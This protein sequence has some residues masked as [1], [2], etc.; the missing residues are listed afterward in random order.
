MN[1]A[2]WAALT[3]SGD[4]L[5]LGVGLRLRTICIPR[6]YT[7]DIFS[8][9]R[10]SPHSPWSFLAGRAALVRCFDLG[11]RGRPLPA[12]LVGSK[13]IHVRAA[14]PFFRVRRKGWIPSFRLWH[15][16]RE[17]VGLRVGY[18]LNLEAFKTPPATWLN[19]RG[20][21]NPNPSP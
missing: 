14:Y 7:I 10:V 21:R 12:S 20:P 2:V 17:G 6:A 4:L 13:R 18:R 11:R 8:T 9:T 15:A 5:T 1:V 19:V 16:S 3:S